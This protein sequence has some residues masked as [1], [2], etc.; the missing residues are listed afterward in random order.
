MSEI[1]KGVHAVLGFELVEFDSYGLFFSLSWTND[2][3][4]IRIFERDVSSEIDSLGYY[5]D[6]FN[7]LS[8]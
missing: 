2:I 5:F 1:G 3:K 8:E 6:I 7:P 4:M